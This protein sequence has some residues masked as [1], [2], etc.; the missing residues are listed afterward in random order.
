MHCQDCKKNEST[1]KLTQIINNQKVVLNLCQECAEKRG[2]H[3]PFSGGTFPLGE[4]LASVTSGV[5]EKKGSQAS[6]LKCPR[7]GM[8]FS[9][10]PKVG[11]FGCGECYTAFRPQL[12][13]MLTK[14]H[15]TTQHKGDM[16][17]PAKMDLAAEVKFEKSLEA[18]LREA[19][20]AEDFEKAAQLRDKIKSAK[21]EKKK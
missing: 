17:V 7:C 13:Q 11:R 21:T 14:I 5:I 3:N 20:A 12:V 8:H 6:S 9:E 18:Q 19:I 2:F 4:M 16:P 10:F 15:G 1:V